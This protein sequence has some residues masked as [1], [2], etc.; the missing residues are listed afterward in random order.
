MTGTM[1]VYAYKDTL[2]EEFTTTIS[3]YCDLVG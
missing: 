1:M 2:A 3:S